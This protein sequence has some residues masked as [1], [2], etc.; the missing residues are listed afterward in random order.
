MGEFVKALDMF[1]VGILS[2]TMIKS[3]D[4]ETLREGVLVIRMESNRKYQ[5]YVGVLRNKRWIYVSDFSNMYKK[6]M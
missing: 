1:E 5:K 2:S 4:G 6:D 3:F